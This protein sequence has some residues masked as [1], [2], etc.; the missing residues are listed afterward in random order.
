MSGRWEPYSLLGWFGSEGLTKGSQ[1]LG[2][3]GQRADLEAKIRAGWIGS[4]IMNPPFSRSA[5]TVRFRDGA[6]GDSRSGGCA[7]GQA[8]AVLA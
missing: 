7:S 4:F 8:A 6:V 1:E 3:L 2:A 5:Q